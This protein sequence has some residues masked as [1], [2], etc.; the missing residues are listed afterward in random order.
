MAASCIDGFTEGLRTLT[1]V[2]SKAWRQGI[3]GFGWGFVQYDSIAEGQARCM[4]W[5]IEGFPTNSS[6]H[7]PFLSYDR[8]HILVSTFDFLTLV[9]LYWDLD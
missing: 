5:C 8:F 7:R 4:E 9:M 3:P 2:N 6:R 1:F